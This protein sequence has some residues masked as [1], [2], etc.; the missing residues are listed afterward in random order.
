MSLGSRLRKNS[1]YLVLPFLLLVPLPVAVETHLLFPFL[2]PLLYTP[3]SGC[4]PPDQVASP[5]VLHA[6][7]AQLLHP[8][9]GRAPSHVFSRPRARKPSLEGG[10]K[11]T[12]DS[13]PC[14]ASPRLCCVQVLRPVGERNPSHLCPCLSRRSRCAF[15]VQKGA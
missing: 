10:G 7:R 2:L 11:L 3:A 6:P 12:P 14:K 15:D 8:Q 5:Q 1:F 4:A 9:P 13:V